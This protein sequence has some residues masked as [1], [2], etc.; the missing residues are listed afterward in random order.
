MTRSGALLMAFGGPACLDEVAPFMEELMGRPVADELAERAKDKYR[1]IGGCSPLPAIATSIAASIEERLADEGR[2]MPVRVGMR[3]TSPRIGDAF[4]SLVD[5][6][7]ESIAPLTL[8]PFSSTVSWGA[9]RAALDEV[10]AEHPAVRVTETPGYHLAPGFVTTLAKA[11]HAAVDAVPSDGRRLLVLTA[12]S[13]PEEDVRIDDAYVVQLRETAAAVVAEMGLERS[14][15]GSV[16][17]ALGFDTLG[18]ISGDTPWLLAYQS[19]GRRPGAWLGPDLSDV[20]VAAADVGYEAIVVSP[21]GFVTDHMETLYDLD[22]V[23]AA[24]A[25][26]AGLLFERAGVPNAHPELIRT[27]ATASLQALEDGV[28]K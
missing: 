24:E 18:A 19:K 20:I 21:I 13:L 28:T 10:A 11:A 15:D 2:P 9:Y 26:R 25:N 22:V 23:A 7:C 5:D 1:A 27:L 14:A 4:R 16:A 8:S 6:G 17:R 3:Y 12:H